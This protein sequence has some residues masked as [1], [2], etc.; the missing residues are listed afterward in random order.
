MK[1]SIVYILYIGILWAL[2]LPVQ[3]YTEV[4]NTVVT[5]ANTGGTATAHTKIYT[6]VDGDVVTNIDE[7]KTSTDGSSVV[8]EK[9]IK[10]TVDNDGLVKTETNTNADAHMDIEGMMDDD[11]EVMEEVIDRVNEEH[12]DD[13]KVSAEA[14]ATV[15]TRIK[16]FF[17][18]Y[19]FW[20]L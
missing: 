2:A 6:E 10:V 3:A 11:A 1:R 16:V 17:K 12:M 20:W 8:V 19:V 15:F 18:T 13:F 5:E 4:T 14:N 9:N 7:K